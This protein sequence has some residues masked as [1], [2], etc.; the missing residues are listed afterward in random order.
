[1]HDYMLS[2][3][4]ALSNP[5]KGEERDPDAAGLYARGESPCQRSLPPWTH[6][7]AVWTLSWAPCPSWP[8]LCRGVRPA[9]LQR[10]LPTLLWYQKPSHPNAHRASRL[11]KASW[12]GLW[13]VWLVHCQ[14][15]SLP[16]QAVFSV[17]WLWNVFLTQYFSA[18]QAS[19]ALT[20]NCFAKSTANVRSW[21]PH[22]AIWFTIQGF[23]MCHFPN[24]FFPYSGIS[25]NSK[26]S[27]PVTIIFFF[28][29]KTE[30]SCSSSQN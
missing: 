17:H 25:K 13:F 8:C 23:W 3:Y 24:L 11:T 4:M 6:S 21:D 7:K 28:L 5:R 20:E 10:S 29:L 30:S 16:T 27:C 9:D 18:G 14:V 15:S 26:N 1:M 22:F 2:A 12:R 19:L